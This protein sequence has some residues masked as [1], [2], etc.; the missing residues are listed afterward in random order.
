MST[1]KLSTNTEKITSGVQVKVKFSELHSC[2]LKVAISESLIRFVNMEVT[3]KQYIMSL[4]LS[5]TPILRLLV[6]GA[7]CQA[8]HT[9]KISNSFSHLAS[10]CVQK[11][12]VNFLQSLFRIFKTS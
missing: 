2:V 4:I 8:H 7:I 6:S 10:N 9:Q 1:C 12:A 3:Y 11:I 5:C